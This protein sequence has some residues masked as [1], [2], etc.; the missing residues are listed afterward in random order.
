MFF[1]GFSHI[2]A[3]A[4]VPEH[5]IHYVTAV[6]GSKPLLHAGHIA[7]EQSGHRVF[8]AYD[9]GV[10]PEELHT[11]SADM[12]LVAAKALAD[13]S[14]SSLTVLS[15]SRPDIAPVDAA[16]REDAYA[17]LQ[18]PVRS[19][20]GNLRNMLRRGERECVV[21]QEEWGEEHESLVW[22]FCQRKSLSPETEFIF[23][24]IRAYLAA[25]PDAVLF[26]ARSRGENLLL[27]L[28]VGDFSSLTTAFYLFAFRQKDCPPGVSDVLLHAIV[29]EAEDRGCQNLNLGLDTNG[30]IAAFKRKWGISVSVP[31]WET[32]WRVARKKQKGVPDVEEGKASDP[33]SVY[34]R[35]GFVRRVM[36]ALRG[37]ERPFD[38]LQIEVSSH[39]PGRCTYCP[40]TTKKHVWR[41]RHMKKTTFAALHPLVRQAKRVHLQGWGEPLTHPE[42]FSFAAAARRVGCAVST[43]TCGLGVNALTAERLVRSGMD[44][45]A[46]SLTGIDAKGNAA[47]AGI[48]VEKVFAGI[49]NL[50]RAKRAAGSEFPHVHLAYLLC[51]SQVNEVSGLVD[52]MVALDVPVAVISTLDY[53]ASPQMEE[54]AF[55]PHEEEKIVPAL[56][57]LRQA[58]TQASAVGREIY[59]SLPGKAERADCSERIQSCLY[60]DADGVI[61]PCIYLNVPTDEEDP[62]RRIYGT[63]ETQYP[64]DIWNSEEY[65]LFRRRLQSGDPGA[66]CRACPK[67][68]AGRV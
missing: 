64:L 4:L 27:A 8:V 61:A 62:D 68:C 50:N 22:S 46:F 48:P 45:V 36:L 30:G 53:L 38:C 17:F 65:A 18:L 31:F 1:H 23:S 59:Y 32:T 44:I 33:L 63:V 52:L 55:A 39:C 43:T 20:G 37:E 67:R 6:A 25:S 7:Y 57:V 49:E 54:E 41:S 3:Q 58:A 35:P 21:C 16:C 11:S 47:R 15:P 42:F 19:L 9:P 24:R 34:A 14:C 5:L 29:R 13:E 2:T 51:A 10:S 28:A 12:Q 60:V 56:A 40:H 66:P 26:A